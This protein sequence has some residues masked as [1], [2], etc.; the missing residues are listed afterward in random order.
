LADEQI[1]NYDENELMGIL[2]DNRYH[3]PED[4]AT[5]AE[6]D[7]KRKINVYNPS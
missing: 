5:D 1:T 2:G 7:G 6:G 3:S 4:S